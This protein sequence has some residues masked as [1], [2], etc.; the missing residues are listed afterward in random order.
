MI[1]AIGMR[2]LAEAQLDFTHSRNLMIVAVVLVFGLGLS[3]GVTTPAF[4]L[5]GLAIPEITISGLFIAVFAGALA[6]KVLP[7]NV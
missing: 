5:F 4:N 3:N 2:T 1:A 6:N 7:K